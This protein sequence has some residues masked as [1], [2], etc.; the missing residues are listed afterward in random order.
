METSYLG[1][2]VGIVALPAL[3]YLLQT[4]NIN[5]AI[6]QLT[7]MTNKCCQ[8]GM[9]SGMW[10]SSGG[11]RGSQVKLWK[12]YNTSTTKLNV[13]YFGVIVMLC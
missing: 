3:L 4:V 1:F 6:N 11:V 8:V 12:L 2:C 7:L 13:L 5:K 9:A 10:D